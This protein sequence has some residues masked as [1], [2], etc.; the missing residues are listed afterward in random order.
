M[1]WFSCPSW[2]PAADAAPLTALPAADAALPRV[3]PVAAAIP[4]TC[5]C[6]CAIWSPA[7][8]MKSNC[9]SCSC[10]LRLNSSCWSWVYVCSSMSGS[11]VMGLPQSPRPGARR[12]GGVS[13]QALVEQR[14]HVAFVPALRLVLA[15]QHL[16]LGRG[17]VLP[18]LRRDLVGRRQVLLL[19]LV[20][21]HGVGA[22]TSC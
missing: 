1:V 2:S 11:I 3:S 19:G 18:R 22:A 15:E 14:V 16:L 7:R 13:G 9:C 10:C 12:V 20:G 4:P 6:S 5:A 17:E 21:A 8:R